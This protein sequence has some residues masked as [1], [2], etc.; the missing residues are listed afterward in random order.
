MHN[1]LIKSLIIQ[2]TNKVII[3]FIESSS[4]GNQTLY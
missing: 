2:F 4:E 3:L 1:L